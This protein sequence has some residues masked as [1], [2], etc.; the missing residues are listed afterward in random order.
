MN[1]IEGADAECVTVS[2]GKRGTDARWKLD[3]DEGETIV[4]I[5]PADHDSEEVKETG[6]AGNVVVKVLERFVVVGN[7]LLKSP[8]L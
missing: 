3:L 7:G 5:A 2:T 4:P 8:V 6:K 1:E